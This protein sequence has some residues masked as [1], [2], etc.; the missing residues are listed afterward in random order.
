[1]FGLGGDVYAFDSTTIYLCL[2]VYEWARFRRAKGGIKIH[3]LYDLETQVPAFLHIAEASAHGVNAMDVI[4]YEPGAFFVFDRGYNDFR[5]LHCINEIDSFFVARA[6]GNLNFK[7]VKWKQRMPTNV[8]SDST[9]RLAGYASEKKYPDVLRRIVFHD[10]EQDR[11]F[12]FLTNALTLDA[13]AVAS[14]YKNRWQIELLFKWMKQHSNTQRFWSTTEN[15]VRIQIYSAIT[16]F[17]L[18]AIVHHDLHLDCSVYVTIQIIGMS[19][20]DTKPL[21][22]L[23]DKSNFNN[24]KEQIDNSELLLFSC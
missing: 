23:L 17:C 12:T 20:T 19:L 2:S 6:K 8:I 16:A 24:V 3:T 13:L 11:T 21:K 22:D 4:P 15:A 7:S 10:K 18:L 1:M 5:R 14:L 9:F